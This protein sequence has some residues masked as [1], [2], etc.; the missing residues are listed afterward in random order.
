MCLKKIIVLMLFIAGSTI[1]FACSDQ[2]NSNS[3]G[4]ST[5]ETSNSVEDLTEGD[6]ILADEFNLVYS[7]PK[8][9]KGRKV[10]FYGKIFIEPEK[11]AEGTYLQMYT[12]NQGSDGNTVVAIQDPNLDVS[13]GDIVYVKGVVGDVFEG[14]NAFGATILAPTILASSIEKS[15]YATAFSPAL[16]VIE[17]NQEINQHGYSMTLERI[18]L[19]ASETRVYLK[20]KN[21]SSDNI[22]FYS[23][24][25]VIIQGSNQI[26]EEDN[27]DADYQEINSEIFPGVTSQGV[28]TFAPVD[29][30]GENLKLVFEGSSDDYYLDFEPF[31][32][33]C[34][35][36]E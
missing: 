26:S 21:D 30:Q 34:S 22:S 10:E 17:V 11:D 6:L 12:L 23:F 29:I 25:S 1:F 3:V 31:I 32:F 28:V 33:E 19:A 4:D 9:Y 7:N 14:T 35:L 18:E 13:N 27:W 36:T 8:E 20:I 16:K 24:N 15:D 5:G 2:D